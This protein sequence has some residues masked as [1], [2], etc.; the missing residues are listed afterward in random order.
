MIR[1]L[2]YSSNSLGLNNSNAL[3]ELKDQLLGSVK[4]VEDKTTSILAIPDQIAQLISHSERLAIEQAILQS[5]RFRKMRARQ[6]KITEA[7]P[8]TLDWIFEDLANDHRPSHHFMEWLGNDGGLFWIA[9]KA[10]SGKS[11]LMKYLARETRVGKAL[12]TWAKDGSIFVGSYFFWSGGN[13]MQKSQQGLLQSL[14]YDILRQC[15]GLIP[16]LCPVR[17]G[18]GSNSSHSGD[19]EEP[20]TPLELLEAFDLLA[21]QTVLSARFCFFVDGLDE[22]AG[23][24]VEVVDMLKR[25]STSSNFKVCVSSRPWTELEIALS[26]DPAR[27]LMLQDY[28]KRDIKNYIHD[29]LEMDPRF[30][31]VATKDHEF[32]EISSEILAKAQGVFLWIFLAVR[33]LLEGFKHE[34]TMGD[35]RKKLRHIPPDLESYFQ[36]MLNGVDDV[37]YDETAEILQMCLASNGPLDLMTFSFLEQKDPDYAIRSEFAPWTEEQIMKRSEVVAKRVKIRCRDLVE[38][39]RANTTETNSVL[40][41]TPTTSTL[42]LSE[43]SSD[44]LV[45]FLHRTVR[46]FFLTAKMQA[47]LSGWISKP[48]NANISLCR[49]LLAYMKIIPLEWRDRDSIQY[50]PGQMHQDAYSTLPSKEGTPMPHR[51]GKQPVMVLSGKAVLDL[52]SDFLYQAREVELRTNNTELALIDELDRVNAARY[53]FDRSANCAPELGLD[54]VV[55]RYRPGWILAMAVQAGLS[56]YISRKIES[57]PSLVRGIHGRPPLYCCLLNSIRLD[58][59]NDIQL[60]TLRVLLSNKADPNQD[61]RVSTVW[62]HFLR[63]CYKQSSA[64]PETKANWAEAI[65]LLIE[66]GADLSAKV[67]VGAGTEKATFSGRTLRYPS[68]SSVQEV[69]EKCMPAHADRIKDIMERNRGF[70]IWSLIGWT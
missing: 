57:E 41:S 40:A 21:K 50:A 19:L 24:P 11:T 42:Q 52:V 39:S 69:V 6:I 8:T 5:L 31:K 65:I 56:I 61:Y 38:I 18:T 58:F 15:P 67:D 49:A 68:Y 45:D 9:G 27:T 37:Y 16:V 47:T 2:S 17:W 60:D 54:P 4:A 66:H 59:E 44:L 53:D 33:S 23:N 70:T 7:H 55:N 36:R 46:D 62:V 22:Y 34:D 64:S 12:N 32:Q 35:L 43:P 28:T 10:G 25:F 13:E 3:Q 29:L 26:D 48:F 63:H 20:W 30:Q 1:D 51:R 14:L